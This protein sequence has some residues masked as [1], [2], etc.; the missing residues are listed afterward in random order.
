MQKTSIFVKAAVL[1]V[2]VF[3]MTGFIAYRSGFFDKYLY[4][5]NGGNSLSNLQ[6]NGESMA[7]TGRYPVDSARTRQ[8]MSGS[9]SLILTDLT[10][11][12]S[13]SLPDTGKTR[14]FVADSVWN[15]YKKEKESEM[16]YMS[17]SKSGAVIPPRH[18]ARKRY[19]LVVNG[20][21]GNYTGPQIDSLLELKPVIDSIPPV[22]A[23][24]P[25]TAVNKPR[26]MPST[27]SGGV[28]YPADLK[29]QNKKNKKN[30]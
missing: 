7:D 29:K 19:P 22:N 17:S 26:I 11:G 15:K 10:P 27:K 14:I 1:S 13:S 12:R 28:F 5:A 4:S 20:V 9:K 16:M 2:F 18:P 23:N 21:A 3:L 6:Q 30:Q 25:D 8:R 24:Q